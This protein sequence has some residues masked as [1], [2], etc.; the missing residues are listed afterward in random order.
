MH[1]FDNAAT[2]QVSAGA[3]EIFR[4]YAVDRFFNPSARYS[5]AIAVKNDIEDARESL[6]KMMKGNGKL[7]F[8]SGGTE[9]DNTA[10]FCSKKPNKSRIIISAAEHAAVYYAANELKQRGHDVVL[11]PVLK[12]G[13]VVFDEFVK[14]VT[15]ETSLISV[16]HVNNETGGVNDIKKLCIAAKKINPSVLFHC[17]GVQALGKIN[18]HLMSL[19]VDLYSVSAHK[20][21]APKGTGALFIKKGVH[22]S[23]YIIGGGQEGSLRSSTEN[24]GGIMAFAY[25][26][27]EA[28]KNLAARE[29][30]AAE[31]KNYL[32]ETL[33]T[34]DGFLPLSLENSS[35][36]IFSFAMNR[37]RGEVMQ[38]ALER[39]GFLIGTGS[40][41]SSNKAGKRI[42]DALGLNGTYKDGIVR[43]SFCENNTLEEAKELSSQFISIYR[44]LEK[45]GA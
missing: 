9:S 41:C 2:T 18:V 20:L 24:T 45:Y 43:I 11:C 42:P 38:H 19:G 7:I 33:S 14:L 31:I 28:V 34:L 8:T 37:V 44:E 26:A 30:H 29:A 17:D 21:H 40:A 1:Y 27:N 13:T 6:L 23:P 35:Y 16:I 39:K 36:F 15:P 10:L 4:K 5:E 22:I 32:C 12:D 25:A 3:A